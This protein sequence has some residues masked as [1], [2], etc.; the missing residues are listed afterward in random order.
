V[1]F[2]V[3]LAVT[4]LP[5]YKNNDVSRKIRSAFINPGGLFSYEGVEFGQTISF[6]ALLAKAQGIEGV[7]SVA[8]SKF[9]TDNSSSVANPGVTLPVGSLA[10]L[11][12]ANLIIV[13]TG[14]LS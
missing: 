3:T 2:Y 12:T 14:G 1:P 8:A 4:A 13:V 10:T 11:P 5:S 7:V 6:S 9:N